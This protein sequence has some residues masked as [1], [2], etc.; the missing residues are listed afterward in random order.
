MSRAY[1]HTRPAIG[2]AYSNVRARMLMDDPCA[3]VSFETEIAPTLS[4]ALRQSTETQVHRCYRRYA[5]LPEGMRDDESLVAGQANV[6]AAALAFRDVVN[7]DADFVAYKVLVGFDCVYAPAW[8]DG[9]RCAAVL[10][11]S[12]TSEPAQSAAVVDTCALRQDFA[13]CFNTPAQ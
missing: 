5:K 7:A 11:P 4:L 12:R 8:E 3:I 1:S 10:Q 9:N 2:A 13:P 6:N